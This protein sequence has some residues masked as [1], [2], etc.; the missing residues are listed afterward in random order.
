[1]AIDVG[2]LVVR[3]MADTQNFTK[4]MDN[5]AGKIDAFSRK[6]EA[7]QSGSFA[8]LG[9]IMAV[10]TGF[11]A[12]GAYGLKSASD[13]EGLRTSFDVM[14]G[15][16][17]K[18]AKLFKELST[19]ANITPFDTEDLAQASKTLLGFGVSQEKILPFLKMMGDISMG[20]KEKLQGLTLA[21]SQT[22]AAGRLM[23]QDLLQMINQGFN[24]LQIISKKTGESMGQLKKRMEDGKISSEEVAEAFKIATSEGGQFYQGMEKGSKSFAGLMSTVSDNVAKVARSLVGLDEQGNIIKDSFF[25]K[26][27]DAAEELGRVLTTFSADVA[28]L[29]LAATLEKMIPPDMQEKIR[30]VAG[31]I[32]GALV[33]ALWS[34]AAAMLRTTWSLLPFM[35]A[36]AGLVLLIQKIRSDTEAAKQVFMEIEP[37]IVAVATGFAAWGIIVAA[38]RAVVLL[39]G[40]VQGLGVAIAFLTANPIM[41]LVVGLAGAS[42][43]IYQLIT[44]KSL[45]KTATGALSGAFA[46]EKTQVELAAEAIRQYQDT[47]RA[48]QNADLQLRQAKL[49]LAR[50]QIEQGRAQSDLMR[51][52]QDSK[53]PTDQL[54]DA[55]LRLDQANLSVEQSANRVSGAEMDAKK[56]FDNAKDAAHKTTPMLGTLGDTQIV[57]G[58]HTKDALDRMNEHASAM[59]NAMAPTMNL[60]PHVQGLSQDLG[61]MARS[62]SAGGRSIGVDWVGGIVR[63]IITATGP[64]G[65]I[66]NAVAS[67][68]KLLGGSL[69]ESGPL[70]G[71]VPHQGGQSIGAAWMTGMSLAIRQNEPALARSL[72]RVQAEFEKFK[73]R[74]KNNM[75]NMIEAIKGKITGL[76]DKL[77]GLFGRYNTML[78]KALGEYQTPTEKKMAAEDKARQESAW[79]M[80]EKQARAIITD[81]TSSADEIANARKELSTVAFERQRALDQEKAAAERESFDY[82]KNLAMQ[83]ISHQQELLSQGKITKEQYQAALN[84][85]LGALGL[86]TASIAELMAG[87]NTTFRG[88]DFA[89]SMASLVAAISQTANKIKTLMGFENEIKGKGKKGKKKKKGKRAS[90]GWAA[91]RGLYELAEQG[92]EYVLSA[93]MISGLGTLFNDLSIPRP[94]MTA[95]NKRTA[96]P[97]G[98]SFSFAGASF[99]VIVPSGKADEFMTEMQ[100]LARSVVT[101][102]RR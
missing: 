62:A 31:A 92:A 49:D 68:K 4:G 21:F 50:A 19:M 39:T 40:V 24:P 16:A 77:S 72:E 51:L 22:Q 102:R 12:F 9:G 79:A 5:A 94:S 20:N 90:G 28:N 53:T 36:G 66:F 89:G 6:M 93:P 48:S 97:S 26:I 73:T 11:V 81:P 96:P 1:V 56:A 30:L 67:A 59:K 71:S 18:G 83:E 76:Q 100:R 75:E 29:G 78:E 61:D 14:L 43:A 15:S 54:K 91:A 2:N 99:N 35:V 7:A 58:A 42:A 95:S 3:L 60:R 23:G 32:A 82:K 98:N 55:E 88:I 41:A 80:Q 33:P 27:K 45:L 38:S 69:P 65:A 10:A 101:Q 87:V 47:V 17:E 84:K 63:G 46:G 86:S 8:L 52:Q 25:A 74:Y 85:N 64:G 37:V 70:A 57:V 13:M 44:G 34:M